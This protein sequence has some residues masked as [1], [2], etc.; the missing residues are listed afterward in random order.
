MASLRRGNSVSAQERENALTSLHV[1]Q[2]QRD[3][4]AHA[5]AL[6]REGYRAEDI[7]M[8]AA[9]LENEKNND[10]I[11]ADLRNLYR[12]LCRKKR[13]AGLCNV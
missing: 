6:L 7:A 12:S 10:N 8:A 3:E 13:K 5:L 9:P 2:G 1:A 11:G 4:A